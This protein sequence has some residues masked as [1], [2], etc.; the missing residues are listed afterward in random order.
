MNRQRHQFQALSIIAFFQQHN[1]YK[2]STLHHFLD[3]NVPRRTIKNVISRFLKNNR[4]EYK[5]IPG[6]KPMINTPKQQKKVKQHCKKYPSMPTKVR[7][8]K[9]GL[10][11]TTFRRIRKS[12]NIQ[13]RKKGR[14]PKYTLDQIERCIRW[15]AKIYKKCL[16]IRLN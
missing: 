8:Q 6:R 7:A 2:K 14:K 10:D 11:Q 1:L 16:P 4:I 12:T 3:Q 9:L 15:S 5:P 13:H